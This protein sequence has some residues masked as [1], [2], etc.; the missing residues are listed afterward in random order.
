MVGSELVDISGFVQ[1]PREKGNIKMKMTVESR[2]EKW[3]E[4]QSSL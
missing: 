4:T 1:P 2:A 3:T